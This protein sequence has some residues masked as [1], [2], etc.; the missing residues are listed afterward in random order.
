MERSHFINYRSLHQKLS[1]FLPKIS[2]GSSKGALTAQAIKTCRGL[3]FLFVSIILA[4]VS[5]EATQNQATENY[6]RSH[7]PKPSVWNQFLKAHG[8]I[9]Q[10]NLGLFSNLFKSHP[11]AFAKES[12]IWVTSDACVVYL[13]Q[14]PFQNG[15]ELWTCDSK[16]SAD[17]WTSLG[18]GTAGFE[19]LSD[20]LDTTPKKFKAS[21]LYKIDPREIHY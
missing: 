3:A 5:V 9:Q 8:L 17:S 6:R 18:T 4:W 19:K 21:V 12:K 16:P 10:K 2:K 1:L 14:S 20:F 7:W 11:G 15:P 13:S